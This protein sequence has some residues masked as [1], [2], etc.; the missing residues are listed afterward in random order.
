M[1]LPF[2]PPVRAISR[3]WKGEDGYTSGGCFPLRRLD[4]HQPCAPFSLFE[5]AIS[6]ETEAST[7]DRCENST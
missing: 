3:E 2:G 6:P 1:V 7:D 5:Q 4:V